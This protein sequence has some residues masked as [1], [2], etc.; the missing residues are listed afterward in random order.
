[1]PADN[2]F[3]DPEGRYWSF[4]ILD[5]ENNWFSAPVGASDAVVYDRDVHGYYYTVWG[6]VQSPAARAEILGQTSA[7]PAWESLR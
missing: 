4:S 2:C 1:M 5:E 7:M 3:G 6:N